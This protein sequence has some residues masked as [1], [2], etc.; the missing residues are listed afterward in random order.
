VKTTQ[1]SRYLVRPNHGLIA[2]HSSETLSILLI[3]KEKKILLNSYDSLGQPALD[4]SKDKFLVQSCAV[5]SDFS[6]RY[7]EEKASRKVD[8][9]S[10]S[11]ELSDAITSMWNAVTSGNIQPVYN[12]KLHVRHTILF[13]DQTG[14]APGMVSSSVSS[15]HHNA[16]TSMMVKP[17][18]STAL[19]QMENMTPEQ[20]FHEVASL[21][22]KYDELVSFSVNLTAERDILSNTLEQ[23][24][25]DLN[26]EIAARGNP[27][28]PAPKSTSLSTGSNTNA[29]LLGTMIQFMIV[30][31][32][33][34]LAGVKFAAG[35]NEVD[36]SLLKEDITN[37]FDTTT[38]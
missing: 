34:F 5:S 23:T 3:N 29:S 7:L 4:H 33:A 37:P 30:A 27:P 8:S 26:R 22:R 18:E 15:N 35:R 6:K 12:K 25:R 32:A 31:L 24:K 9:S 36:S 14:T 21:R 19:A 38:D 16:A 13:T 20:M 11:R 2:P 28:K 10:S 17:V 1:P